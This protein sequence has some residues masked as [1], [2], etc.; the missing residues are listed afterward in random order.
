[1][2]ELEAA[3]LRAQHPMILVPESDLQYG[4]GPRPASPPADRAHRVP[5]NP[6]ASPLTAALLESIAQ[7]NDLA[8]DRVEW[9]AQ[10]R[11]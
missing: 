2:A 5:F 3:L 7:I 11:W 8:E 10:P 1:M 9:D 6:L 4:S